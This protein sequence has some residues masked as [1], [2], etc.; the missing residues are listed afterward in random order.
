[1]ITATATHIVRE[2]WSY[3]EFQAKDNTGIS[4]QRVRPLLYKSRIDA[5]INDHT[6]HVKFK[7]KLGKFFDFNAAVKPKFEK[8]LK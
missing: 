8:L 5:C 7:F 1:M 4:C 2:F 6:Y 3:F